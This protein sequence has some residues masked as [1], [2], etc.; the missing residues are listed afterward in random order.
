[1]SS[2]KEKGSCDKKGKKGRDICFCALDPKTQDQIR[3]LAVLFHKK[4][5]LSPKDFRFPDSR[6]FSDQD[7]KKINLLLKELE[8]KGVHGGSIVTLVDN[9]PWVVAGFTKIYELSM[10]FVEASHLEG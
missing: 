1:M 5:H 2:C 9:D 7:E 10:D 3:E 6:M 8:K 4:T